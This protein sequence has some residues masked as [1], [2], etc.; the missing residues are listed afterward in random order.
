MQTVA[1]LSPPPHTYEI[2]YTKAM[3]RNNE[4]SMQCN[5]NYARIIQSNLCRQG[6]IQVSLW[7]DKIL[8][9]AKININILSYFT[10]NNMY[11]FKLEQQNMYLC[12]TLL[13]IC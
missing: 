9:S 3:K 4:F 12:Y 11:Y 13:S 10:K 7:K 6:V 1:L 8:F 2:I 5:M